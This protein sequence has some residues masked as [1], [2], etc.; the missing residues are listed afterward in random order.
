MTPA[1]DTAAVAVPEAEGPLADPPLFEA[2][3]AAGTVAL[4]TADRLPGSSGVPPV[5]AVCG[6]AGPFEPAEADA[7]GDVPAGFPDAPLAAPAF[8][9]VSVMR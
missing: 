6:S 9:C 2:R 7:S 5:A 8:D 3:S 1:V 4:P